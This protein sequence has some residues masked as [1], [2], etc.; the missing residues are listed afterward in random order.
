MIS[1]IK[2]NNLV[3]NK[4]IMALLYGHIAHY[5]L[6]TQT[7]P[8]IYYLE[9]ESHTVGPIPNHDLVEGYLMKSEYPE[10]ARSYIIYRD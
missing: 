3:D 6:D 8:F 4:H 7:H 9:I 5:F 2:Q 10:V 1:Y